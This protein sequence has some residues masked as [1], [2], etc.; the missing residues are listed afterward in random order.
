MKIEII[1]TSGLVEQHVL[2]SGSTRSAMEKISALIGAAEGLDTVNLRDGRVMLVDDKGYETEE[3]NHGGGHFEL[4]PIRA[5]K[6][7]NR[8]A[9]E[10]Y[11]GICVPGTTH[12]IVGDVAV[13]LDEDF[14]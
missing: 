4:R 6:P 3:V 5:R 2:P 14:A 9:T 12:Q 10:L 7:I 8:A 1:R 11:H 13:V